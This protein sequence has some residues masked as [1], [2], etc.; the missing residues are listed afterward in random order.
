[1][2]WIIAD[3]RRKSKQILWQQSIP[4][5]DVSGHLNKGVWR[6]DG[7]KDGGGGGVEEKEVRSYVHSLT[8]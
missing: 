2:L 1:M 4:S 5:A 7:S 8:A 3:E 6:S